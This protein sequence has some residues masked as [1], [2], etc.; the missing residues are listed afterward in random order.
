MG[1]V[2]EDVNISSILIFI[3]SVYFV[4]I[5]DVLGSVEVLG[6]IVVDCSG[7]ELLILSI[8]EVNVGMDE[9]VCLVV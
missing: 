9:F 1:F 8:G 6:G 2:E 7:L 5:I 3:N 4:I